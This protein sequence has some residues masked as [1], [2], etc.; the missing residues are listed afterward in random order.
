MAAMKFIVKFFPE[1]TIK[2]K[3][4]RRQFVRQL[5]DNVRKTLRTLD[6]E[7][8]VRQDWDKL[9]VNSEAGEALGPALNDAL[10]DSRHCQFPRGGGVSPGGFR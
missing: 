8:T 5:A 6:P 10:E 4:V 9:V 2:S 3:P 1:I 7:V